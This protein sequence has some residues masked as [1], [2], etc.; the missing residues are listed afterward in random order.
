MVDMTNWIGGYKEKRVWSSILYLGAGV[1]GGSLDHKDTRTCQLIGDLGWQNRFKVCKSVSLDLTLEYM[2]ADASF[3]P[4]AVG[5]SNHFHGLNVYVGA[6]YRFNKRTFDR[7]GATEEEAKAMLANLKKSQDEAAAAK[8]KNAKLQALADQQAKALDAA[9]KLA[10]EQEKALAEARK[11]ATKPQAASAK[12]AVETDNYN[13]MLFYNYGYSVLSDT[14]KKRLDLI[15]EH[16]KNSDKPVFRVDGFADPQT[17]S[18]KAN[19]RLAGKRAK[20]AADYLV[21]KGVDASR[22]DVRNCG[23]TECPFGKPNHNRIVVIY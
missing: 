20:I 18:K 15:A 1:A 7:S 19:A 17:G 13:E 14:N 4:T 2:L 6:T 16:I 12:E 23:T 3:R 21:S 10:A 8:A 9:E 5:K 11:N 22:L